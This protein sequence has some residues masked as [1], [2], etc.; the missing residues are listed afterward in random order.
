MTTPTPTAC[1]YH[2]AKALLL[3]FLV[4]APC[5]WLVGSL[6]A[7]TTE[8]RV[9]RFEVASIRPDASNGQPSAEITSNGGLRATH[10]S[11]KMLI[12]VA[13]EIRPE[14]VSGGDRWT[15]DEQFTVSANGPEGASSLPGA[16]QKALAEKCLQTLLRERFSLELKRQTQPASGY[17]LTVDKKGHKLIAVKDPAVHRLRQVGRWQ[18]RA[19][20]IDMSTLVTFLSVHLHETVVDQTGLDGGY[21]FQLNWTPDPV[22][23][24]VESLNGLPEET[25]IPAVSEQL[26]LKL[27]ARKVASDQFTIEHAEKPTEN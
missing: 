26:G 21:D 8:A 19:Q 14:Q 7:Q 20:G 12:E 11:L 1:P 22:P 5:G 23:S 17:L 18:L 16:E 24:S 4:V 2:T 9:E 27:E 6:S 13:Y 10:A 15:D 3:G 25:L